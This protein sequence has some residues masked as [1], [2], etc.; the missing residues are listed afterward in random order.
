MTRLAIASA[1]S[2]MVATTTMARAESDVPD[3][4][5]TVADE[6]GVN[7]VDLLGAMNTTGLDARTYECLADGLLCPPKPTTSPL[8]ECV[9]Q[10][11]SHGNPNAV[12]RSSGASG[13]GQFLPSTWRTTP[14]GR[15][16]LSVF[17]P[18]ANRAA[19]AYMISAGRGREFVGIRGC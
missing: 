14:Q 11:E 10:H 9:I 8:V 6:A 12:N 4:V 2:L 3:E 13:L 16:G 1:L 18:N 15:A 7:S 17:D 19:V 5:Q